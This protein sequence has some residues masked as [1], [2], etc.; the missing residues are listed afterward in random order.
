MENKNT[1]STAP[2]SKIPGELYDRFTMNRRVEPEYR[3]FDGTSEPQIKWTKANVQRKVEK[4]ERRKEMGYPN[5]VPRVMEAFEKYPVRA[6][7]VLIVGSR[8]P[9]YEA[10]VIAAGGQPVTVDYRPVVCDDDRIET[11]EIS[12]I[13]NRQFHAAFSLSS[14]EHSGLGR[15]GDELDP[16]GDIKA[17]RWTM[18]HLV[19]GGLFYLSVPTSEEDKLVFNGHRIYGGLRLPFLLS[20]GETIDIIDPES[21]LPIYVLKNTEEEHKE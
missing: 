1:G 9:A 8:Q 17:V 3:Y 20:P 11:A 19:S 15:Y 21:W 13:G 2:P 16:D 12:D 18:R 10:C 7:S 6:M 14:I 4:A 5:T